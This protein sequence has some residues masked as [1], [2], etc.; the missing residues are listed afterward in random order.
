MYN[1]S[2]RFS[3]AL[4]LSLLVSCSSLKYTVK[5]S[6]FVSSFHHQHVKVIEGAEVK[7]E[8]GHQLNKVFQVFDNV[9]ETQARRNPWPEEEAEAGMCLHS[10]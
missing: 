9:Q 7:S 2:G 1:L 8:R 3:W 10:A 5:T 4:T 6:L